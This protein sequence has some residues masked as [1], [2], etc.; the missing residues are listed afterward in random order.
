MLPQSR[1]KTRQHL[2]IQPDGFQD[3][4]CNV[5]CRCCPLTQELRELREM[6]PMGNPMY[7][8]GPPQQ[9]MG[10]APMQG[11]AYG[12][13]Q[14]SQSYEQSPPVYDGQPQQNATAYEGTPAKTV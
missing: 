4:V 9:Y 12:Q 6:Y 2:Q 11:Q 3:W 5:F 13:P 7:A 8:N 1:G 14:N 10:N